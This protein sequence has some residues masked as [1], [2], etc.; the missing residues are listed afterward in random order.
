MGS[1]QPEMDVVK[2][3]ILIVEPKWNDVKISQIIGR[4]M[5]FKPSDK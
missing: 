3:Q 1:I 4:G 5:R 2:K